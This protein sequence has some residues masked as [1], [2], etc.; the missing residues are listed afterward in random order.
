[1]YR[2]RQHRNRLPT[3]ASMLA[4]VACQAGGEDLHTYETEHLVVTSHARLCPGTLSLLESEAV[5]IAAAQSLA[6]PVGLEIHIGPDTNED[7]NYEGTIGGCASGFGPTASASSRLFIAPHELVH[8]IRSAN[9]VDGPSLFEEGIATMLAGGALQSSASILG[10]ARVEVGPSDLLRAPSHEFF[11]ANHGTRTGA[12][13]LGWLEQVHDR[14]TVVTWLT[15]PAYEQAS[16]PAEHEQVFEEH[17]GVSF[18]EAESTWRELSELLYEFGTPCD[19]RVVEVGT[20]AIEIEGEID[21][22]RGTAMG[23]HD[24][25]G[26]ISAP[27]VCLAFDVQQTVTLEFIA[28][29]DAELEL[30]EMPDCANVVQPPG[31]PPVGGGDTVT[32]GLGACTWMLRPRTTARDPRP[33]SVILNTL[34]G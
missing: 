13:F 22:G 17:F 26:F 18:G 29:S 21:C 2:N 7:C 15:S 33:F 25:E 4:T 16:G 32:V 23:P 1:M 6:L 20:A 12:H 11:D 24:D 34:P 8:V 10:A 19:D 28:E 9:R 27:P 30:V 5:R 14:E 3:L 31:P